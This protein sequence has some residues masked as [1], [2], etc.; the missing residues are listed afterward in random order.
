MEGSVVMFKELTLDAT[1]ENII[2]ITEF[3][4]AQLEDVEC[5][6]DIQ[7][8][9]DIAIDE[10]F[11]N[12]AKY[13]YSDGTGKV[14]VRTKIN[15]ESASITFIDDGIPYNPL[16]KEVPDIN[17]TV[18]ER[19]PGGIG[20]HIVRVSMDDIKYEYTNNQNVLTIYKKL[21]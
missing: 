18:D 12:I 2:V 8:L 4:D 14:T 5:P 3:I 10:L 19:K 17:L 1:I 6:L 20:I 16:L 11:G 7:Y 15:K 9:I 13:A 21:A